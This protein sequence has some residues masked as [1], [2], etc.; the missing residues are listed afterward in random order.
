M[1]VQSLTIPVRCKDELK[2]LRVNLTRMPMCLLSC[3][4][5]KECEIPDRMMLLRKHMLSDIRLLPRLRKVGLD[6]MKVL[7]MPARCFKTNSF[8]KTTHSCTSAA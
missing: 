8:M 3:I 2:G 6:L 4:P 7:S 1:V 5:A